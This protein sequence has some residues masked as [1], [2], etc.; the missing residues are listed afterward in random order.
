MDS[1]LRVTKKTEGDFCDL[2]GKHKSRWA[3]PSKSAHSVGNHPRCGCEVYL[4]CD[5]SEACELFYLDRGIKC[6]SSV[7]S[8]NQLL[9]QVKTSKK[10]KKK[11][12]PSKRFLVP[13]GKSKRP[14]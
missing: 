7:S 1:T 3:W 14:T 5:F 12:K 6:A 9:R 11:K 4:E 2:C 8:I 13:N 10:A